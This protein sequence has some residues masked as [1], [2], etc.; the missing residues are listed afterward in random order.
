MA[1]TARKGVSDMSLLVDWQIRGLAASDRLVEPFDPKRLQPSSYDVTLSDRFTT[2]QGGVIDPE[3]GTSS[4]SV[5]QRTASMFTLAPGDTVLASTEQVVTLPRNIAARFEGKSSLGRI[6]LTTH[7]TAGFIDPGF[8][9]R[10]V[11]E[12][13]NDSSSTIVLHAGMAIGQLCFMPLAELPEHVYGECGNHYQG[14]DGP[15]PAD[16]SKKEA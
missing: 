8:T 9:G 7:T 10:I 12:L 6:F 4:A 15:V 2:V 14:Q 13:R 1:T 11:L 16:F 5:V 3:R